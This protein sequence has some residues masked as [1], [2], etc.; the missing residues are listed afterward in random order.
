[1]QKVDDEQTNFGFQLHKVLKLEGSK[2]SRSPPLPFQESWPFGV[3]DALQFDRRNRLGKYEIMGFV[4]KF[5]HFI[6]YKSYLPGFLD[7]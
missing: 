3:S 4:F 2:P 1:M 5:T 7:R 6:N